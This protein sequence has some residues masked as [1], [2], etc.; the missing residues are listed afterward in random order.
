MEEIA[1]MISRDLNLGCPQVERTLALLGD[2]ATI[3]F[4]ARYRKDVTGNL[5]EVQIA[6]IKEKHDYLTDLE[7]RR[8]VILESIEA[9]GKLSEA[10][11]ARIEACWTKTELEDLYLPY[12]P[13]RRTRASR[14]RERGLEGL[15]DWI[16]THEEEEAALRAAAAAYV[17]PEKE[18]PDVESALDGAKDILAERVAEDASARAHV[19]SLCVAQGEIQSEA[20]PEWIDKPSKFSDY[21]DHRE[22]VATIPSHRYLA[23]VRGIEAGVLRSKTVFPDAEIL[24]ALRTRVEE[25]RAHPLGSILGDVVEDAWYRLMAPSIETDIRAEVKARSDAEALKVFRANLRALL[26]ASPL[27]MKRVLA[28]DPGYRSGCKVAVIDETGQLLE[29]SVVY[30]MPPRRKREAEE[31]ILRL[32]ERRRI[33]AVAIGNGTAS[34]DTEAF[35]SDLLRGR[36]AA[37]IPIAV[38]SEAGASV[39]SASEVAREEFPDLDVTIR[40]AISIGRRLQD[41]LA[42]LVKIDPK[43]IGVGQYQHDVD[44]K[45]LKE[46]LQREVESCVNYVG[47]NVNTASREL[48][49]YVAGIGGALA[50]SIVSHRDEYGPFPGRKALLKVPRLGPRAFEQAA[51]F[52]RVPD[53]D[54]PLD[55]SAVHPEHYP[56]VEQMAADL[57]VPLPELIGNDALIARIDAARYIDEHVGRLT[58]QDIL[59]E[60]RRPGRDPREEFKGVRFDPEV[61]EIED[62]KEGMILEGI[63]TNVTNFGCFVDIGVHQD[64]LVHISRMAD[65]FVEDPHAE[66]KA[67]RHVKVVVL[68]VDIARKRIGLSMRKSDVQGLSAGDS[69]AGAAPGSTAGGG[70]RRRDRQAKEKKRTGR[71]RS[72]A[73]FNPAFAALSELKKRMGS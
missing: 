10:L 9:Q 47:V 51:G 53:A 11:R 5:D 59:D 65:R 34:R 19:R 64:G 21:Y 38:V 24:Q 2:G 40:G 37:D 16:W 67:G 30:L 57:G 13:K 26:L 17:D 49:K 58:L 54:H 25:A 1:R 50:R 7:A 55:N 14:A 69:K 45:R 15:A 71:P 73:P 22:A 31:E 48:L 36:K 6:T 18:V 12:R 43:S 62:L 39:Y 28:L 33:Q 20:A 68:S 27:G 60:L 8:K 72:D 66:V 29:H 61:K 42:E 44:Q 52:L 3:P 46:S 32:I 41:P 56:L 70:A 4:I 63:V 23:I 35:I